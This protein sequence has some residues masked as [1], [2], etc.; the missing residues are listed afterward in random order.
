MGLHLIGV[1]HPP[2]SLSSP[3]DPQNPDTEG[4]G[5]FANHNYSKLHRKRASKK[6]DVSAEDSYSTAARHSTVDGVVMEVASDKDK[7]GVGVASGEES[8]FSTMMESLEL[9]LK[10]LQDTQQSAEITK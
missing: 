1:I 8:Q 2:D 5:P 4:E 6:P 9:R 3:A 10:S 7:E